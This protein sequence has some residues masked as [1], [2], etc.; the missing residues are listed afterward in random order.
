MEI[1]F[2]IDSHIG[3]EE[4]DPQTVRSTSRTNKFD[5]QEETLVHHAR[6]IPDEIFLAYLYV[7]MLWI[8][9]L[10]TD[11]SA[12]GMIFIAIPFLTYDGPAETDG[13]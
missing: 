6:T 5:H 8:C 12:G 4:L 1:S 10:S 9:S 3:R 13:N 11:F 7:D 2:W